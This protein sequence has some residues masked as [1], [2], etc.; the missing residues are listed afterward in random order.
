M[1]RTSIGQMRHRIV[2]EAPLRVP[3]GAGGV[4][5][6]WTAVATLWARIADRTGSEAFAAD[7]ISGRLTH[8]ITL[9]PH[10]DLVPRHRI[11]LAARIFHILAVRTLGE[12]LDRVTCLCEERGL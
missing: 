7:G 5:E 12:A 3:D 1:S 11:R 8:E 10:A 2:V 9:R 4:I 6:T